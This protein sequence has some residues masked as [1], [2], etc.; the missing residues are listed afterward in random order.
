MSGTIFQPPEENGKTILNEQDSNPGPLAWQWT[1]L[2]T[3]PLD[4]GSS[5]NGHHDKL[6]HSLCIS[7]WKKVFKS[8]RDS[9]G[10]PWAFEV[11]QKLIYENSPS[12][13]L[14]IWVIGTTKKSEKLP[15]KWKYV[16]GNA[17]A[18]SKKS[19][20]WTSLDSVSKAG[21]NYWLAVKK[22]QAGRIAQWIAFLLCT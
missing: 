3:W 21:Q 20:G 22:P 5:I 10:F 8:K 16:A 18:D 15:N 1:S 4:Y 14:N 19:S 7:F 13:R 9:Q 12:R 2:T 17:R 11:A 6:L